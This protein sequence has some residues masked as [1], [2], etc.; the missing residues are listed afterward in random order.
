MYVL[1]TDNPTNPQ[2]TGEPLIDMLWRAG[3]KM[4]LQAF[5]KIQIQNKNW[6]IECVKK[7]KK[8]LL[9]KKEK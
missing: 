6:T 9:G 4:R 1:P 7:V 8:M 5:I 3:K 2:P